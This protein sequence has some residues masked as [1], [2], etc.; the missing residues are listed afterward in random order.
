MQR[1]RRWQQVG[2]A[3][4]LTAL[5]LSPA[6]LRA[7]Q[8][9]KR[10]IKSQVEAVYPEL[11]RKYNLSGRVR[12]SVVVGKDGKVKNCKVLGGNA[13]LANAAQEAL[14]EWKFVA[15]TEDTTETVEFE[16]KPK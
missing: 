14:K 12:L 10:K 1:D 5:A 11:A 6:S 13:V 2:L 4:F 16:F 8:D 15:G 9:V 7:Q 3:V